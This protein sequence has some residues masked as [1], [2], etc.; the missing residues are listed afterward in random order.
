[1]GNN[2]GPHRAAIIDAFLKSEQIVDMELPA[3]SPDLNRIEYLGMS[4]PVLYVDVLHSHRFRNCPTGV[5]AI[6]GVCGV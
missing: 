1:M 6:T 2:A 5:M 3:Y 4:S